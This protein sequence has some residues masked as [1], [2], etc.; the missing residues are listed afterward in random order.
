MCIVYCTLINVLHDDGLHVHSVTPFRE[1]GGGCPTIFA[2][3]TDGYSH[4]LAWATCQ[5]M[6]SNKA[7]SPVCMFCTQW[8]SRFLCAEAQCV[9][10]FAPQSIQ[11]TGNRGAYYESAGCKQAHEAE[12]THPCTQYTQ[13]VHTCIL[14]MHTVLMCN[15]TVTWMMVQHNCY[16]HDGT[17][18]LLHAW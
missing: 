12:H 14:S 7:N 10:H 18:Q 17:S 5:H 2:P 6:Q 8:A 9:G 13:H 15:T 11:M 16:M 4:S 3:W 1:G